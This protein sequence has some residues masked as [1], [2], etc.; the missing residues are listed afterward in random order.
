MPRGRKVFLCLWAVCLVLGGST[1]SKGAD[2]VVLP[3]IELK[4]QYLSNINNSPTVKQSDYILSA[5]PNVS[6]SYNSEI[7]KLEGK[8]AL[9]GLAYMQNSG[10]DK[11]NQYY[12]INSNHKATPRLSLSLLSSYITD[13]TNYAELQTSGA[14]IASILRTAITVN[15]GMSY[16]L[17]ERLSTSVGYGFNMVDYQSRAYNNYK[18]Q[19]LT[20]GFDYS[21]NEKTTLLS[22]FTGSYYKYDETSNTIF[23][24]GPQI[25]FS[26]RYE[27]KWDI[28]L[29]GGANFSRIKANVGVL[30][31]DNPLGFTQVQQS[32][33]TSNNASPFFTVGTNYRWE[34]GALSLKYDRNQSA[35][36]YGNQS[37][38]N[39]FN[40]NINQSISDK[41]KL[42]LNPYFITSTIPSTGSDYNSKYSGIRP[43]ITYKFTERTDIGAYYAFSYRTVTGA[44]NYSY[45]VNDVWLTLNYTYPLHYQH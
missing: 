11:I 24:L 10:L 8:L 30:S 23:A 41:L 17:T 21:L 34:T 19:T 44:S 6:F 26:H 28:S 22:R 25:G 35:N 4:S 29:L 2:W 32:E 27:E 14:S 43:G 9:L 36:A 13:S 31:A 5:R 16:L 33:Q 7:T 38:T 37:Q 3:G 45:P 39:N 1:S 12:Y 42:S 15:P 18:G 40:L 20:H